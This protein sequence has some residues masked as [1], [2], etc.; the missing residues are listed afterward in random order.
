MN[1]MVRASPTA[2]IL[3]YLEDSKD[4]L[5]RPPWML[6]A[7][8]MAAFA[9]HEKTIRKKMRLLS[10]SKHIGT[11][12]S[13]SITNRIPFLR[14]PNRLVIH[15]ARERRGFELLDGHV[16]KAVIHLMPVIGDRCLHT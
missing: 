11:K 3:T 4:L 6:R 13:C 15:H 8:M 9:L 5:H 2:I 1:S 7:S 16:T 12:Y 14:M 10:H